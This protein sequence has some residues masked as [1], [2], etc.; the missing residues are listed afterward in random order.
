MFKYFTFRKLCLQK[1]KMFT[2]QLFP[3]IVTYFHV[4]FVKEI[5]KERKFIFFFNY[6]IYIKLEF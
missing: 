6:E 2:S 1:Q 5:T 3:F 4:V